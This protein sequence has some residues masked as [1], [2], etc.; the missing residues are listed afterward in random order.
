MKR[1]AILMISLFF[2]SCAGPQPDTSTEA[3]TFKLV[4][5][6]GQKSVYSLKSQGD[7]SRGRGGE[8][9]VEGAEFSMDA[10]LDMEVTSSEPDGRWS[11]TGKFTNVSMAL[12]GQSFP[13]M[14]RQLADQ[15]FTVNY[16]KDGKVEK[17]TGLEG[18]EGAVNMQQMAA[19]MNP[20]NIFPKTPVKVGDS[21]PVEFTETS[22]VDG[23]VVMEATKGTGTLKNASNGQATIEYDLDK[24]MNASSS[25]GQSSGMNGAGKVNTTIVFDLGKS[26]ISSSRSQMRFEATAEE[27]VGAKTETIQSVFTNQMNIDLINK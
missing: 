4:Q 13:D 17:I 16:D 25:K 7:V 15:D 6:L 18:I 11:L 23:D 22:V 3:I 19:Q 1:V 27:K 2:A 24:R 9:D 20:T 8:E 12:N 26:R 10:T 5:P 21:W 14:A